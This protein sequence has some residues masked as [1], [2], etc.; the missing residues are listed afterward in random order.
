MDITKQP[1]ITFDGIILVKENFFREVEVPENIEVVLNIDMNLNIQETISTTQ[2]DTTV[3]MKCDG[4]DVLKL[5][6]RFVGLFSIKKSDENMDMEKYLKN[7][8]PALMF[9]FIREHIATI[10]QKSGVPPVLLPPVNILAL[11]EQKS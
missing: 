1:G 8:S 6:T 11:I 7:H 9:P 2:L 3:L 4:K 10:T 5:E